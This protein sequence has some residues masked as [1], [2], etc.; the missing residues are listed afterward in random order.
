MLIQILAGI[1]N[2]AILPKYNNETF[3]SYSKKYPEEINSLA[4]AFG[5]KVI[6]YC[7]LPK[8]RL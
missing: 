1:D 2:K 5:R 8:I 7:S 6:I 4:P 3:E